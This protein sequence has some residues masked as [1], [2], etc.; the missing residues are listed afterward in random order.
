MIKIYTVDY[1]S[2]CRKAKEWLQAHHLKFEE[3]NFI[4]EE[5]S[6]GEI[7][8][9]LTLTESGA[10]DI[11]AKRSKA[12]QRLGISLEDLSLS[13]LI[14]LIQRNRNLLRSPLII[15]EKRLQVGYN[16]DEIRKFMPRKVREI[17]L[18]TMADNIRTDLIL[19]GIS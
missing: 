7:L 5:L 6:E 13:G 2:S 19:H 9:L 15:D 14:K 1:S 4:K 3:V 18:Q 8:H 10:D 12:Y 17:V 16:E 11:I